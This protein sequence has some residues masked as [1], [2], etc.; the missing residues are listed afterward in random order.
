MLNCSSRGE[1]E[2]AEQ[3]SL[4][5][6]QLLQLQKDPSLW[7]VVGPDFWLIYAQDWH[8]GGPSLQGN[9]DEPLQH[10]VRWTEHIHV[11]RWKQICR[12]LP[13]AGLE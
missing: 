10:K 6:Q 1:S 9:P 8:Q 4:P 2:G 7:L 12:R 13:C 3:M 11:Q 5:L